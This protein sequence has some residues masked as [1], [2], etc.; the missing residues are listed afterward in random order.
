MVAASEQPK[1]NDQLGPSLNFSS[2]HHRTIHDLPLLSWQLPA[3]RPG[4]VFGMGSDV[5]SN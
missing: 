1:T 2:L 5:V 3:R 4:D